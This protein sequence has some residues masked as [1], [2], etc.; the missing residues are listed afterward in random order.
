M[1]YIF[2]ALFA[3]FSFAIAQVISKLVSKHSVK[4]TDSLM[5]YFMLTSI[6]FCVFLIP[7]VRL[8]I[9]NIES[10]GYLAVSIPTVMI[11]YYLFY[12]AIFIT[13]AS[14]F[15]P[16]FQVQALMAGI[17]AFLFLGERFAFENYFF[18]GLILIGAIL[19]SFEEKMSIRS[20]F[21]KGVLL[22]L[23]MQ[24]FH[25]TSNLFVSFTLEHLTGMEVIFWS[26][27][28]IGLLF[29]PFFYLKRPK[30]NYPIKTILTMFTL[31]FINL[32][33][34]IALFE[35]FKVNLTVSSVLG[36]LSA[37][38]VFVISVI[39]S[40]FAPKLLEHHTR[41]VYIVRG[42]GLLIILFG[43]YKISLG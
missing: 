20:F 27:L 30:I 16:L 28:V 37:P 17:L 43:A 26:N 10:I 42:V 3:A 13:D 25:A 15:S 4:G 19:V 6:S 38:T 31:S 2:L 8:E 21:N 7:F 11:G 36:F 41:R 33:G 1:S 14:T 18:M 24:L 39:S 22:I 32:F 5:A 40:V 23:F 34:V 9:P 12:K 35:A 29:F